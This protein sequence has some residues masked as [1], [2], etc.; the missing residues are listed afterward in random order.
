[1][2]IKRSVLVTG[3]TGQQGGAVAHALLARGHHVKALTRKPDSE[4]GRKLASVGAELVAGDFGDTASLI[5]AAKDVDTMFLMGSS[6]GVGSEEETRQGIAAADAAKAA[7][8]GHL[9]YTSVAN[10]N[11]NTGVPHFD[12]KY[13]VE[14]HIASI[15]IPY[16]ISA[17][18]SFMENCLSPWAIS[19]LRNGVH[20][21]ILPPNR[22]QQMIALADI[23]A[24]VVTMIERREQVF[25]KRFDI[26]GDELSGEER[27]KILT[28]AI[29]R[30]IIYQPFPPAAAREK[31][32]ESI[33]DWY[34][35]VGYSVDIPAL[36]RDFPEIRWRS[37]A[38][39]AREFDWSV[40]G[41]V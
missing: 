15:G 26:A 35:R 28:Q 7:G 31:F 19:E 24:F 41:T 10:G 25:G 38:D 30:P 12:S 36:R 13:R 33:P 20:S 2:T 5:A 29:G 8:I 32:G 6:Q 39:W 9:V 34:D 23:T 11:T 27:A 17:P 37:Y 14:Q 16:T 40:L 1:M 21:F 3:A 18:V 22:K 4:A